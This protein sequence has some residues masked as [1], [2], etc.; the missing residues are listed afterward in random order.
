MPRSWINRIANLKRLHSVLKSSF[1]FN[2]F[3]YTVGRKFDRKFEDMVSFHQ[4][5]H[6]MELGEISV[7]Y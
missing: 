1:E 3:M 2:H 4:N 5:L 6:T 7:F